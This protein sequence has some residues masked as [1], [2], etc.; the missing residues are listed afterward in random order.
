[1]LNWK[2]K[3]MSLEKLVL[4][5]NKYGANPEYVLA[6]GGNTSFKDDEFMYVKGSGT[7][8]ATIT[9]GGFVKMKRDALNQMMTKEY[10]KD[11]DKREAEA[12]VDMMNARADVING[13]RPS[14]EALLL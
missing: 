3:I 11:D 9:E 7:A 12:L 2:V 10:S 6:G 8:L 5:S 14:V 1:M 13:G 4:M